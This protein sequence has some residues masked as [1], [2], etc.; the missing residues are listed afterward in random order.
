MGRSKTNKITNVHFV[1][2]GDATKMSRFHCIALQQTMWGTKGRDG[3]PTAFER[4]L[5]IVFYVLPPLFL[6]P[7]ISHSSPPTHRLSSRVPLSPFGLLPVE[8][9]PPMHIF[10][11]SR[12]GS[13][14]LKSLH[15]I[16]MS[17]FTLLWSTNL[18]MQSVTGREW[19]R[20]SMP[21]RIWQPWEEKGICIA[22]SPT[23]KQMKAWSGAAKETSL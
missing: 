4:G 22:S 12:P 7:H 20:S 16:W 11:S 14:S 18:S 23:I 3:L 17:A 1:R 15:F 2:K 5:Q 19:G 9:V 13:R 8:S 6:T 10:L 21:L